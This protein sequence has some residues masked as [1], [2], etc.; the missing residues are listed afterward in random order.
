[1]Q[2]F[3]DIFDVY[4]LEAAINGILFVRLALLALGST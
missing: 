4:L 3:L 2:A 1:M